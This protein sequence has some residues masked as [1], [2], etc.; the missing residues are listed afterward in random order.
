MEADIDLNGETY[1]VDSEYTT[2]KGAWV[3][4]GIGDYEFWGSR[5]RDVQVEF[6]IEDIIFEK[7]WDED[8]NEITDPEILD[9]LASVAMEEPE[10][11]WE[12]SDDY[13]SD[14]DD[15]YP[16]DWPQQATGWKATGILGTWG[17]VSGV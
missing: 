5:G 10:F 16:E 14:P 3:D 13:D 6:E 12:W 9:A 11:F 1:G 15:Y 7:A 4:N 8:G 2:V 17:S